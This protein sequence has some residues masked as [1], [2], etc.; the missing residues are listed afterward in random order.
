MD[1]EFE[2]ICPEHKK[3]LR[4]FKGIGK[5]SG[6]P[7]ENWK[8]TFKDG[9]GAYCTYVEWVDQVETPKFTQTPEGVIESEEPFPTER[10]TLTEVMASL[11]RLHAKVNK[12]L[13]GTE[14]D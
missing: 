1:I 6:K 12:L 10:V 5:N 3:A 7:Y 14:N 13:N 2:R 4:Q 9:S 8:C 11:G